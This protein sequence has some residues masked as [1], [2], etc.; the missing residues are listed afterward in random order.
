[1]P[2][3]NECYQDHSKSC[4]GNWL[5]W[6][7][8]EPKTPVCDADSKDLLLELTAATIGDPKTACDKSISSKAHCFHGGRDK[9][10]DIFD[11]WKKKKK[12]MK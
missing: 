6:T 4:N 3:V 11:L 5:T 1:M 10:R 9:L 2:A 8:L 7:L 12:K